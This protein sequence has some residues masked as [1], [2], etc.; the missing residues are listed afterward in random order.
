MKVEEESE[1]DD[2]GRETFTP[3]IPDIK[4]EQPDDGEEPG[5]ETPVK[6]KK[7]PVRKAAT[8]SKRAAAPRRKK[9]KTP[10]V[11]AI[12]KEKEE[13]LDDGSISALAMAGGAR[14]KCDDCGKQYRHLIYLK[15]HQDKCKNDGSKNLFTWKQ[16][17]A[18]FCCT[19]LECGSGEH[20]PSSMGVWEHFLGAHPVNERLALKC[21]FCD[22]LFPD[23]SSCHE[24]TKV[25]HLKKY[26]CEICGKGFCHNPTLKRHIRRHVGDKPHACNQCD[27]RAT[28]NY[29]VE[30]HKRL[31]H[32]REN[33]SKNHCCDICGKRFAGRSNL[34]EHIATHSEN[35]T[36]LCGVCGRALKNKQS[37]NR[38]LFTHGIKQSCDICGKNFASISSL[39][40]HRRDKHNLLPN[41]STLPIDTS[42]PHIPAPP[43]VN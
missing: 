26:R 11:A 33:L 1:E 17:G 28:K 21:K 35:R 3:P 31:I 15:T 13:V 38:H 8:K 41:P 12:K 9:A 25:M 40:I 14:Y 16:E 37:L 24:H 22:N 32:D 18:N 2:P 10:K 43:N 34:T 6:R 4:V 5:E 27:Y 7:T 19:Y 29:A 30:K 23:K 20:W 39:N 36:F 42:I